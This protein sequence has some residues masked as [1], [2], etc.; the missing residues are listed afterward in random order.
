M[1]VLPKTQSDRS[2]TQIRLYQVGLVDVTQYTVRKNR[3][4]QVRL[5]NVCVFVTQYIVKQIRL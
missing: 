5:I 4:Y 2:D 3:L 1:Y